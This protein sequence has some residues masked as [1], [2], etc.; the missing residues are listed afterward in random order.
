MKVVTKVFATILSVAALSTITFYV[1]AV[2]QA[3]AKVMKNPLSSGLV[4]SF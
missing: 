3:A 1:Q 2:P 4:R